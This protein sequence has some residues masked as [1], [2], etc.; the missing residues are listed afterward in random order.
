MVV[1]EELTVVA[2][3]DALA[4]EVAKIVLLLDED[5]LTAFAVD[6]SSLSWSFLLA[7]H[8]WKNEKDTPIRYPRAACSWWICMGPMDV[9]EPGIA[10]TGTS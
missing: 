3:V 9:K 5:G 6:A 10:P 1:D 2:L 8:F 4:E 7:T